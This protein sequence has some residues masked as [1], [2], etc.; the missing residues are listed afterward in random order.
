[1]KNLNAGFQ[2]GRNLLEDIG[3]ESISE[4]ALN[5]IIAPIIC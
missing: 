4:H 3:V 2:E 1:M 5:A